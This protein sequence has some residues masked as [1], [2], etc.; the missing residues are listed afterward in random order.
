MTSSPRLLS[1]RVPLSR[2]PRHTHSHACAHT[3]MHAHIQ[4]CMRTYSHACAHTAMHAHIQP[5]MRTY[6]HACRRVPHSI[7]PRH[8]ASTASALLQSCAHRMTKHSR[9]ASSRTRS[10]STCAVPATRR[11]RKRPTIAY[12]Q[13]DRRSHSWAILSARGRT[14]TPV[15]LLGTGLT[16]IHIYTHTHI[17]T[18]TYTHTHIHIHT[19]RLTE[20]IRSR[21]RSKAQ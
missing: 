2:R 12:S 11:R 4:P 15:G 5:C 13:I 6:M 10:P 17:H 8:V 16:H 7:R 9:S 20:N 18:Y 21:T 14:A 1:W 19:M 3:A